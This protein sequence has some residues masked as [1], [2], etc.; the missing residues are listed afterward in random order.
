M[1]IPDAS[2]EVVLCVHARK[3]DSSA[4]DSR[5]VQQVVRSGHHVDDHAELRVP[6]DG[7]QRAGLRRDG[8][9]VRRSRAP[10][11]S[12]REA[13]FSHPRSTNQTLRR[14]LSTEKSIDR[15]I[16]RSTDRS[17]FP[18]WFAFAAADA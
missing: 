17:N 18:R 2:V 9:R 13:K 8:P 14:A 1:P 4:A 11:R 6:R 12:P 3:P 16:D 15:S 10:R 5:G 7:Q